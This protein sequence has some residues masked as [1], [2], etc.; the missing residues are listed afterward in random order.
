[1]TGGKKEMEKFSY[2]NIVMLSAAIIVSA[3][4]AFAGSI[5]P[6]QVNVPTLS[7]WGMI[8]SAVVLG[9]AGLYS[10]FKRK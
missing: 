5:P 10:I 2:R 7:E 9:A 6:P 4:S 8:G 3:Q 1:M